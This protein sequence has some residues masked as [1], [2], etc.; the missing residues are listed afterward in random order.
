MSAR[1]G[2][3]GVRTDGEPTDEALVAAYVAG[4]GAAFDRLVE[5]YQ[6]R[7]FGICF[8]YFADGAD[9]EDAMQDAFVAL[10]R[11]AGTFRGGAAFSTWMY[12]VAVN[13]CNDLARK[14]ARRPRIAATDVATL[15][16]ELAVTDDV[17]EGLD[18]DLA[19]ALA[20]LDAATRTAIVLHDVHGLPYADVAARLDLPVGTVKSRIH[21]GHARLAEALHHRTGG[22]G[23]WSGGGDSG[24]PDGDP[25]PPA[26]LAR[27]TFHPPTAAADASRPTDPRNPSRP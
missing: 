5:R 1:V 11:R 23:G 16:E 10:L 15:G 3:R 18:A 13:A 9:A 27:P 12:R 24:D 22:G 17:D 8:H 21:R 25:E 26:V 2:E 7:V 20:G 19:A 6:R 4:D 14:R